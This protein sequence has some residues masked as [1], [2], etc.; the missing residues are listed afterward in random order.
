MKGPNR[1]PAIPNATMSSMCYSHKKGTP[2]GSAERHHCT[3][4]H[5]ISSISAGALRRYN[6]NVHI[7][8]P[9]PAGRRLLVQYR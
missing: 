2:Y 1:K 9:C 6:H 4:P 5:P 7:P 3:N 8:P